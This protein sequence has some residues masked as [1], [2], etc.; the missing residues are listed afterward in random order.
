MFF[1]SLEKYA[2]PPGPRVFRPRVPRCSLLVIEAVFR[3]RFIF[4]VRLAAGH[5]HEKGRAEKEVARNQSQ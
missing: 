5:G 4:F 3:L 1:Y 2:G